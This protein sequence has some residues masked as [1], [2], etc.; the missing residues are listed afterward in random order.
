MLN[1]L[2][3]IKK[4]PKLINQLKRKNHNVFEQKNKIKTF[5]SNKITWEEKL[6]RI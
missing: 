5:Y 4:P 1:R 6:K 3:L 2:P